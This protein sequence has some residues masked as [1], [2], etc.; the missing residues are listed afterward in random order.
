MA[1]IQRSL[2]LARPLQAAFRA[3]SKSTNPNLVQYNTGDGY[4]DFDHRQCNHLEVDGHGKLAVIFGGF[5]FTKRQMAK[6]EAI[7]QEHG[8][9]T[10]P[11]FHSVTQM[12][13]PN[14]GDKRGRELAE[15]LAA[16]DQP[17]LFH[18]V[19]GSF[20]ISLYVMNYLGEAY[21]EKHLRAIAFDSCPPQPNTQA[22]AGWASFALQR[23][24]IKD[25]A[26]PL[27]VPFIKYQ[28]ITQEWQALN[29]KWMFSSDSVIPRN[30]HLC[31]MHGR[32]D[33]VLNLDYVRSFAR[34]LRSRSTATVSEVVFPKARHSMAIVEYPDDYKASHIEHLLSSVKAWRKST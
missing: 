16:K 34:S 12:T 32:N 3:Y 24:W 17:M 5:G 10:L 30:A 31:L 28:G 6:H 27:F 7:Y 8:F 18:C 9:E 13:S 20:W 22:F 15:L 29:S 19:S 14:Y 33:P 11:L 25:V 26:G 2:L 23:P 1:T 4:L 21:R